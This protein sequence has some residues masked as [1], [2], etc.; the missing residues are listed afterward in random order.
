MLRFL[1]VP[2][3]CLALCGTAAAQDLPPLDLP[4]LAT[5]PPPGQPQ[6][7][8]GRGPAR[9][10]DRVASAEGRLAPEARADL[11]SPG[12]RGVDRGPSRTLAELKNPA[13]GQKPWCAQER[14]VGT[15]TGF[16]LIN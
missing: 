4:P 8:P 13:E 1:A 11:G 6:P 14:R 3:T 15:G 16:C 9:G 10:P 5:L 7:V 12:L 2:A